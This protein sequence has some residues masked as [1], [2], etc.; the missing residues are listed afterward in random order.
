MNDSGALQLDPL[1][2]PFERE[3]PPFRIGWMRGIAPH[4]PS[5]LDLVAF[6]RIGSLGPTMPRMA[7]F[8]LIQ[9]VW[10]DPGRYG[11][12]RGIIHMLI[13]LVLCC[14]CPR[15]HLKRRSIRSIESRTAVASYLVYDNIRFVEWHEFRLR[16]VLCLPLVP[17]ASTCMGELHLGRWSSCRTI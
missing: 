10:G 13:T 14:G 8:L 6:S 17:P 2:S 5:P 7:A 9:S 16:L 3:A 1:R 11:Y 12:V 15:F 4:R